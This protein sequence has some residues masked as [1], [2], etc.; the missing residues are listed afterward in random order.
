MNLESLREYC[1]AKP[2]ATEGLPF[3]PTVLVL[4]VG[5]KMFGLLPLDTEDLQINLKC[6]PERAIQLREEHDSILPG[7]VNGLKNSLVL[8][9]ID[10]SYELAFE[11]LP[12][13]VLA[14]LGI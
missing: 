6:D 13:K 10:H 2:H 1:L 9:L 4:K 5:G 8:E 11:S 14:E 7:L 3:G 12:K